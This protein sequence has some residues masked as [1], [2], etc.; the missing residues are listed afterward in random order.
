MTID[1]EVALNSTA[2]RMEE[3]EPNYYAQDIIDSINNQ[4]SSGR[5]GDG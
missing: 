1:D 3:R 4:Q 5:Q 2:K